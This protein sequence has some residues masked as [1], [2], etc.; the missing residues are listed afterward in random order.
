MFI[1]ALAAILHGVAYAIYLF[2]VY[3]GGSVPNP[4]SWTV[5]AFLCVL[6]AV[7][8]WKASK[9]PLMT[10]QFFTGSLACIIVWIYALIS[11][12]FSGL[13]AMGWA[14]L[15]SCL[16]ACFVWWLTRKAIYANLVVAGILFVSAI[17]TII[18]T[19]KD[20]RV[21]R[22]LPWWLWTFA[23]TL[24][25]VNVIRRKDRENRRW[26]LLLVL[27]VI[28]IAVHGAVALAAKW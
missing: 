20:P 21:E 9:D 26:A 11:G 13:D 22:A 4:S 7:T 23:F 3:G 2:Q 15:I 8:F 27:P 25:F 19:W 6:N 12:K 28:G 5:W 18:G 24:T 17:P 1:S 10:A 14:T 16:L